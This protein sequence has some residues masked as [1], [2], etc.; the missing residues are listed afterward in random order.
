MDVRTEKGVYDTSSSQTLYLF[1]DVKTEG[2]TTSPHVIKYL[3]PLQASEY[4]TIYNGMAVPAGPVTAIGAGNPPLDQV[5]GVSNAARPRCWFYDAPIPMLNS[6]LSNT[7]AEVS[8]I[9]STDFAEQ[10]GNVRDETFNTTQLAPLEAE[11]NIAHS[12]D[13]AVRYWN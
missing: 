13:I 9:A 8:S 7:T 3:E 10:F 11:V 1:V 4:L 5:Q 6:I 12:K 2:D